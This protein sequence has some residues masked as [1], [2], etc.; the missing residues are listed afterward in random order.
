MNNQL[1]ASDLAIPAIKTAIDYI[2]GN[3][4]SGTVNATE[5]LIIG[6]QHIEHKRM[7]KSLQ[8][9][10]DNIKFRKQRGEKIRQDF[11]EHS[12][13]SILELCLRKCSTEPIDKK[14]YF[15]EK[16][17]ENFS[18]M[19]NITDGIAHETLMSV[20]NLTYQDLCVL[21]VTNAIDIDPQIPF[22]P[23]VKHERQNDERPLDYTLY[24]I[25]DSLQ[26]LCDRHYIYMPNG[27]SNLEG[28]NVRQYEGFILSG[29]KLRDK[30]DI[31][32]KLMNLHEI[33]KKD[34]SKILETLR[35]KKAYH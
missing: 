21:S 17:F 3:I 7:C 22:D 25:L 13:E 12:P 23:Y 8:N 24:S 28:D 29:I 5:T 20:E 4:V 18:F 31:T 34:K 27:G 9:I 6:I 15:T 30:G 2:S 32:C 14:R 1:K 16:I 10:V 33:S 26:R 11:C 19:G 35:V